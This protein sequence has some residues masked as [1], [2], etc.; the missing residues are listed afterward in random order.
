MSLCFFKIQT[1]VGNEN[2]NKKRTESQDCL[3]NF[4]DKCQNKDQNTNK[5]GCWENS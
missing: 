1:S 5:V 3:I 2:K 4:E